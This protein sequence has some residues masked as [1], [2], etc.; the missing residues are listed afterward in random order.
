VPWKTEA[1]FV[2]A[3]N[4]TRCFMLRKSRLFETVTGAL[5]LFV[6][7]IDPPNLGDDSNAGMAGSG[8]TGGASAGNGGT[9]AAGSGGATSA[10]TGGKGGSSTGAKGGK[11]GG[12]GK[13]GS[14]SGA[15]GGTGAT[16]GD[17]TSNPGGEGGVP[18]AGEGGMGG[19]PG[20]GGATTGGSSGSG[21][22]GGM[23]T[24][25]GPSSLPVPPT[26]GSVPKPSGTQ[27]NL[28]V[29]DWA[30]FK[31]AITFTF[32]DSLQSQLDHYAELNAVGVPMTFYLV[33]A[34]D[35]GKAGWHTAKNDGHEIGNHTM[36]HC[37]ADGTSCGWG[38]FEGSD[39][40]EIDDCQTHLETTYDIPYV[41]SM[42]APMGDPG[43]QTP[44]STRFLAN[45][46]VND[47]PAGV[48]PNDATSPFNLPCHIANQGETAVGG[49]N[50]ITD[51][52]EANG[53]WRIILNHSLSP[54]A[55]TTN[56]GTSPDG[57]HPV[58]PAEVV[59][60]MTY[61]RD[62]GD[63]W[64][65]ALTTIAAYW[66]AQKAISSVTA[67]HSGTDLVYSWTLPD[68]FPP[69]QYVRAKVNGGTV[70]QLG[71]ELV[72]DN[73]GYYELALDAGS[74]TISP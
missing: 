26:S 4:L 67:T 40:A 37:A 28:Q 47:N 66:R 24:V 15:K 62:K 36:H 5:V 64:V 6:A 16:G 43:W 69:G 58:D 29:L 21:G 41:Y 19:E 14:S 20:T 27:G 71:S 51:D 59:A 56:Q 32:D 74:V 7:C 3:A 38:A 57:Y 30:G 35:G 12:G 48:K 42:A 54:G 31:G 13:G 44:A 17:T 68:H 9:G 33:C 55:T 53:K 45:R 61:A 25:G 2:P 39:D 49:F 60:A 52:V 63:V 50:T 34:N 1:R 70:K 73:H 10:G 11:G 23:V 8:A 46:G 18:N 22:S 72:W 65:D